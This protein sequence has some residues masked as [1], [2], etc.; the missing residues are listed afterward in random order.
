VEEL[1]GGVIKVT[2]NGVVSQY[3]LQS[4]T[5]VQV[6]GLAGND[7]IFLTGLL[8]H[9]LVDGGSGNDL[10]D[11]RGV[12]SSQT[13]L[14]LRGGSENDILIGGA[15]NDLLD[16]GSGNDLLL[17]GAGNDTLKGRDGNDILLGGLGND[18]LEGGDGNDILLGGSGNDTLRGG[19]DN[20]LLIG[21]PGDDSLRGDDG[22]DIVYDW[23]PTAQRLLNAVLATQPSWVRDFV[24]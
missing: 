15:G 20:D 22:W 14:D 10:I 9:V 5:E 24:G 23:D 13:T 2:R 7:Q 21:G 19:E 12:T 3:T 4:N 8:R 18:V 6:F 11:A 16:G 1:A 17:G